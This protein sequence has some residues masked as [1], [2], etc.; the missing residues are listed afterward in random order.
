MPEPCNAGRAT[1]STEI[2]RTSKVKQKKKSAEKKSIDID[3]DR[4]VVEVGPAG[5]QI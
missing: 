4:V 2:A 1:A 3:D 5:A